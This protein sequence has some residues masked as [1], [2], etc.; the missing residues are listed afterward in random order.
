MFLSYKKILK[1]ISNEKIEITPFS[2]EYLGLMSYEM[3]L[4]DKLFKVRPKSKM[5][6]GGKPKEKDLNP[7]TLT[8]D[9]YILS[10]KEF[11]IAKTQEKIFCDENTMALFDGKPS[12]AQ[13]GL[14][15]TN[16]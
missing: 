16:N 7:I 10:P 5:F 4:S 8:E 11:I 9:C 14:H 1:Y 13:I 15:T 2:E 3:H 12:L 6:I